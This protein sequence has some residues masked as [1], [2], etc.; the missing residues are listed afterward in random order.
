MKL[1][2]SAESSE[3]N[4]AAPSNGALTLIVTGIT[5]SGRSIRTFTFADPQGAP[6]PGFIP[7]SHL[8]VHAGPHTNAYSLN[9]DGTDPIEYSISVLRVADGAGGSA[10]MHDHVRVGDLV[11][12]L[13]PRSAFAP[14]ARAAKHLLVAGGI[15]VTPIVSH[16]RAAARWGRKVQ[17]LYTFRPDSAAHVDDVVE[18]GGTDAELFTARADFAVR[19]SVVLREQPVGTH[20]YTCGPGPLI[21]HVVETAVALGWP[22]SRIH[23]ER[24]GI[25]ALDAGDPFRLRLTESS[26]TLDVPSGTSML[27]A[28][29]ATGISIPNLCRQGVCG[30][31]RIPL[32]AGEAVHRDLFLSDEEKSSGE[33]IMPCVSRAPDGCTLE[34]PL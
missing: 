22:E 7:G 2:V 19:L 24:F 3:V 14:V 31:C 15:G 5:Q 26:T 20:L 18:L 16:L 34:V 23:F 29:E 25:D 32:T 12:V 8:V 33:A 11:R 17:V 28:L 4:T 21:D 30:E 10:W 27:E 13:P 9:S 1:A 6:L